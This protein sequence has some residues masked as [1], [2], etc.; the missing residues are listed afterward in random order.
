MHFL[1]TVLIGRA[2]CQLLKTEVTGTTPLTS[3]VKEAQE[4]KGHMSHRA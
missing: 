4:S 2:L 3:G 1:E